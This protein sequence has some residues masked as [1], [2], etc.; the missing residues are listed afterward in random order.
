MSKKQMSLTSFFAK[1]KK[2][3]EETDEPLTTMKKKAAFTRI[4]Q[5]NDLK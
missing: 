1:E 5:E 2:R 3:S 4:E